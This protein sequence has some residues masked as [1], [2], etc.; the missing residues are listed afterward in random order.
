MEVTIGY[1]TEKGQRNHQCDEAIFELKLNGVSLGVA[2]LNNSVMD[3]GL[4]VL[5]AAQERRNKEYQKSLEKLETQWSEYVKNNSVKDT[6]KAKEKFFQNNSQKPEPPQFPGWVESV[7]EEKG[8]S[9][10]NQF[11]N[12]LNSINNSFEK[13]GRKKYTSSGSRSQTFTI[14]GETAKKIVDNTHSDKLV[15]S[16]KPLVGPDVPYKI[17]YKKGTHSDT[18]WVIIQS[19]KLKDPVYN[20][21][22]NVTMKRGDMTEKVILER[23]LCGNALTK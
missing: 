3:Y 16:I 8:Y 10:I 19:R 23:D 22:P 20:G 6:P 17:F 12:D 15:L 9:D 13:Y 4:N 5:M 2:N 14:N 21:M 11:V 18:P 7:A 1:F